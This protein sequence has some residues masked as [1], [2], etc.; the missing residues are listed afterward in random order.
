MEARIGT[1]FGLRSLHAVSDRPGGRRQD[2]KAF[3]QALAEQQHGNDAGGHP[4]A[5]EPPLAARL[6]D[7]PPPDRREDRGNVHHVDVIA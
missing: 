1:T 3:Q 7:E 2:G 6:Q 5:P 4:A